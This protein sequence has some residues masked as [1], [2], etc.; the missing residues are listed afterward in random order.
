M[1]DRDSEYR[2]A[3]LV[4]INDAYFGGLKLKGTTK[5][6]GVLRKLP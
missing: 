4:K 1:A 5:S 6:T 2:L 3:G